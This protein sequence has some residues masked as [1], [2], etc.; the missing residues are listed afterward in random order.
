MHKIPE[1]IHY[2]WFGG[3]EIPE[4]YKDYIQS[5]KDKMPEFK[6]VQWNEINFPFEQFPYAVEAMEAGKMAFVSDVA[7]I[8]ALNEFGGVYL[9]TDVEIIKSFSHLL[10]GK[11]AVLGTEGEH[12]TIG[13]GF[14]AFMPHH[15]IC[16]KMLDYYKRN[17]FVSQDSTMSNTWILANLIKEEYG[18][19][20]LELVQSFEDVVIYPSEYFTAFDPA[21]K[22]ELIS[23][24][25]YC[26][27]HFAAS[28]LSPMRKFKDELK[29]LINRIIFN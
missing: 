21:K 22:Q 10:D 20:P 15:P 29:T 6:L 19:E 11:G 4:K 12:D 16:E 17:H 13:T 25:T 18:V 8:Y 24:N 5:W 1:I 26:V 2:C 27:H 9:D 7:R 14:M 23:E 3:K 28:W